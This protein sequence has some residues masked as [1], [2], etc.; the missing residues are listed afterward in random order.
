MTLEAMDAAEGGASIE[1][2]V[3]TA[4]ARNNVL[5]AAQ[6]RGWQGEYEEDADGTFHVML[7]K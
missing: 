5:L 1:V 3:D 7:R 6:Q 4:A 2:L